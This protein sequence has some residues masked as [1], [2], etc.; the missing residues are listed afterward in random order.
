M[1]FTNSNGKTQS[2]LSDINITPLVDVMMV[3]LVIFMLTAPVLQTG[4]H[5][6]L[7]KTHTEHHITKARLVLTI[8]HSQEI[9]LGST[10]INLSQLPQLL[11]KP[12]ENP[13]NEIVYLRADE[14][15]PFGVIATVMDAVKQA[16]VSNISIVTEPIQNSPAAK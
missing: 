1:A 4:I 12:N 3:L 6:K 14:R 7:P 15:V 9:Y 2:S 5:V 11:N 8:T 16:G 10:P 13:S